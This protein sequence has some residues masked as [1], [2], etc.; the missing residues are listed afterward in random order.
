MPF[1]HEQFKQPGA[2][3]IGKIDYETEDKECITLFICKPAV[4]MN[5]AEVL[6]AYPGVNMGSLRSYLNSFSS[7][8]L[9]KELGSGSIKLKL[10]GVD[11][12]LKHKTH[13]Y[14][15]AKDRE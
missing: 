2:V 1:L 3:L 8:A 10:D 9:A 6:K 5:E 12:D 4:Q 15:N 7:D 11:L 14:L 13:L